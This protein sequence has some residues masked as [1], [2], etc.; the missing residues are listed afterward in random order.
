MIYY[1]KPE[2][3]KS[4][5]MRIS[6]THPSTPNRHFFKSQE[7]RQVLKLPSGSIRI[8]TFCT[9]YIW[10]SRYDTRIV[11]YGGRICSSMAPRESRSEKRE[12]RSEKREEAKL[13]DHR[14]DF[15]CHIITLTSQSTFI[16]IVICH[17]NFFLLLLPQQAPKLLQPL[18]R[19]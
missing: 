12:A 11:Q 17:E 9:Y 13:I 7:I 10:A 4:R 1:R 16:K 15:K 18:S 3:Q 6:N 19:R 14:M 2:R 5:S 8:F